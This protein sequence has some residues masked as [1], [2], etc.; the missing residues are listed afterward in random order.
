V[1]T[2][3][4]WVL[5]DQREVSNVD[6]IPAGMLLRIRPGADPA[7]VARAAAELAPLATVTT[8]QDAERAFLGT[9]LDAAVQAAILAAAAI[10]ALLVL[11]VFAVSLAGDAAERLRRGAILRA[12]GFDRRQTAVLVF[13]G[14]APTA[15]AGVVAGTVTG[16]GLAAAVLR[17]LDP[18]GLVGSPVPPAL[19]IDPVAT[20]LAALGFLAAAGLAGLVAVA[21]DG[22]RPATAGLQTLGEER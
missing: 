17:G 18:N 10:S 15:V 5:L 7:R 22:R 21:L 6:G 13:R 14:I 2:Q 20:T 16:V 8:A 4:Q 3:P 9:P 12:L 11:A 19:V 1:F